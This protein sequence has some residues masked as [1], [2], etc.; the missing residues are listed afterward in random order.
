M[1]TLQF[2]FTKLNRPDKVIN[3][4]SG[5]TSL[6]IYIADK[7]LTQ[8]VKEYELTTENVNKERAGTFSFLNLAYYERAYF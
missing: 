4:W 8:M 1:N 5:Y 2:E 6:D 3:K 7:N